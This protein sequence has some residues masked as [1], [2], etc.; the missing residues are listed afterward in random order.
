[1]GYNANLNKQSNK[2][3]RQKIQEL[4]DPTYGIFMGEV[5]STVDV[6]RTGRLQVFVP[7]LSQDSQTKTGYF[8]AIWSSPF[9]GTTDPQ[10]VGADLENPEQTSQTYGMWMIPPDIGT[11]VLV[12]FGDGNMKFP[13]IISCLFHDRHNHMVPG[14]PGSATFQVGS[15]LLPS[16]ERN[17]KTSQQTFNDVVR[18]IAHTLAE[19][20]VKQG[21]MYDTV[22]GVSTSGARRESPS[23]VF[24]ILTPGPRDPLKPNYRTGGH[25]FIMDDSLQSR[26]I[27]LRTAKGHQILMD[28]SENIMYFITNNGKVWLEFDQKGAVHLYAEAGIHF[29]TK[30]DF[31]LRADKNINIEAGQDILMKAAGD[32]TDEYAGSS[33]LGSPPTGIGGNLLFESQLETRFASSASIF[34]TSAS[35]DI[36]LNSAGVANMQSGTAIN[37]KTPGPINLQTDDK[38]SEKAGGDVVIESGGNIV[39]KASKVLMNSGGGSANDASDATTIG[40]LL[41]RT[42]LDQ[43]VG[44]IPYE[45]DSDNVL[46]TGGVRDGTAP[47]VV[48]IVTE[49]MTAEPWGG[50]AMGDPRTSGAPGSQPSNPAAANGQPVASSGTADS[51]GNPIPASLNSPSGFQQGVSYQGFNNPMYNPAVQVPSNWTRAQNKNLNRSLVSPNIAKALAT[52]IPAVR[53]ATLTPDKA[54]LI[55]STTR[56]NGLDA[57]LKQI[58]LG[59]QGERLSSSNADVA[60]LRDKVKKLNALS[61]DTDPA[62]IKKSYDLMGVSK[63]ENVGIVTYMDKQSGISIN[64]FTNA[65][66]L[67]DSQ[68]IQLIRADFAATSTEVR[69]LISPVKPDGTELLVS[70]NQVAAL[71]SMAMHI[72]VQGTDGNTGLAGSK[73]LALTNAGDFQKVPKA[74]LEFSYGPSV[75]G[76]TPQQRPDFYYR[77]LFEGELFQTPDYIPLPDY[78]DRNVSWQQQALDLRNMRNSVLGFSATPATLYNPNNTGSTTDSESA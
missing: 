1:M 58:A 78:G 21:L 71:T 33:E 55:G 51:N 46:P 16:L 29:R 34:A 75:N 41:T 57:D 3:P 44:E 40:G 74:M 54:L 37:L 35:G 14:M 20:I 67:T 61:A 27:R 65:E 52:S 68:N 77:R 70:D 72:G 30:G 22:R 12:A 17:K 36:H 62:D 8:E 42:F 10:A 66:H 50:H 6:S 64:D 28:D 39:E 23:E 7:A 26:N 48:S 45:K 2:N 19:G 38:L 9:A 60:V 47:S 25:Q 5:I 49:F 63:V 24:G 11:H 76:S 4:K 32:Y 13:I 53:S 18:P 31:N 56:L 69:S 59:P 73:A 15:E 43:P